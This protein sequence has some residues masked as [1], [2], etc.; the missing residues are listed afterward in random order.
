MN[1]PP[2]HCTSPPLIVS[3][4]TASLNGGGTALPLNIDHYH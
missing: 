1:N 4:H 2:S 3:S